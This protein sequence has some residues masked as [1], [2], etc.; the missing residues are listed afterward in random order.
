MNLLQTVE[1]KVGLLVLAVGGL[2]GFMSLQV[3]DDPSILGG[4]QKAWFLLPNAGGLVKGSSVRAAGIPVGVIKEIRLQDGMARV[5]VTVGNDLPLYTSAGVELKS[6][7]IL[8]DRHVEVYPGSPTDPRLGENGQILNVKD[9]GNLDNLVSQVGDIT[10]SLKSVADALNESVTEDGTRK[11]I[12]GR[13]VSNIERVTTDLSGLTSENR[14]KLGEVITQV[15]N[16]T[17]SLDSM[18][19]DEGPN[20]F[21]KTWNQSLSRIDRSLANIEEITE[22]INSGEGAVGKLISDENVA[23]D[24]ASALEGLSGL[25]DSAGR[26]QT[27]FDF[28]G[29]YLSSMRATKSYIGVQIQPG[30]DR[31]YYIAVVDDP[32]GVVETVETT[33]T[34]EGGSESK[35]T[36]KKVFRNKTKLTV[37]FAK[38]FWEFTLKGGMIENSG[39]F[40]L[41]YKFLRRRMTASF[42]AFDLSTPNVRL[43]AKYDLMYGFYLIGGVNDTFDQ[44]GR[45]SGYLGAGLFLTN[46]D[47]KLLLTQSPF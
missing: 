26:I 14:D 18:I 33:T 5:D 47:L 36:E 2:I 3:S 44:S 29:E 27:G 40:G 46:D 16:I 21:K 42:E 39:G 37:L 35:V 24:V 15:N 8:G 32:A 23:E 7:G 10:S 13:I 41:D 6:Q 38:N 28:H 31:Y 1:F 45:R 12:L 9:K 17:R 4:S 22:K 19:N 43:S 20:G 11:H 30:L 34:P 25:V